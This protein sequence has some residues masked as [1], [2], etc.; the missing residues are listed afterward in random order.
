[1]RVL[2]ALAGGLV[3]V[4]SAVELRRRWSARPRPGET[5]AAGLALCALGIVAGL[6]LL[7]SAVLG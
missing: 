7:A 1:M 4:M 5:R 3:A 6:A 2:E